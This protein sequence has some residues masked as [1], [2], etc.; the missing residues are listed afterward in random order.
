MRYKL[1][2]VRKKWQKLHIYILQFRVINFLPWVMKEG[3]G[4][5]DAKWLN[6]LIKKASSVIG[7]DLVPL[8]VVAEKKMR[9]KIASHH[10]KHSPPSK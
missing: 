4:G 6:K 8:E 9:Q 2:F 7:Q 5:G 10:G 3:G 1:R